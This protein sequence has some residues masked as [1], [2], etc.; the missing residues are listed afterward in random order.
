[1]TYFALTPLA[2]PRL[3]AY[4]AIKVN[5]INRLF[6]RHRTTETASSNSVQWV[7]ESGQQYPYEIYPLD[8]AFQA[9]PGNFI[10]A[11]TGLDGGWVPVYIAQTRDL[12]QR[13]EGHFTASDAAAH[14][15]THL[16]AHY[17]ASGQATRCSE[18]RDLIKRWHPESNDPIES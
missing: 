3:R 6:G 15:A 17:A 2:A 16:H 7:G 5:L 4:C 9:L 14:G 11:R 8:V 10:Y 13:L 18:E 12:H 1:M